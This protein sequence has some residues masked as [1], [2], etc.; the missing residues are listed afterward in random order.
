MTF[1]PTDR[2][3]CE[4]IRFE[5]NGPSAVVC[6]FKEIVDEIENL[7][8][9]MA[10]LLIGK[11][12]EKPD[13]DKKEERCKKRV[14]E[15]RSTSR[16]PASLPPTCDE[17]DIGDAA[18]RMH[19]VKK[20]FDLTFPLGQEKNGVWECGR[21]PLFQVGTFLLFKFEIRIPGLALLIPHSPFP[22]SPKIRLRVP[23]TSVLRAR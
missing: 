2:V 10:R 3:A 9:D 4:S 6:P 12:W 13:G 7:P 23:P 14:V 8:P 1:L 5:L 21:R 16:L 17:S 18:P 19:N 15:D 20:T 11:P 22:A